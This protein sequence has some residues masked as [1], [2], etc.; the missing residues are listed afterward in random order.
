MNVSMQELR[1]LRNYESVRSKAEE[2]TIEI[3]RY[4]EKN[5]A[6]RATW[7]WVKDVLGQSGTVLKMALILKQK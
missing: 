2:A 7:Q 3:N 5:F 1:H 4:V 6:R